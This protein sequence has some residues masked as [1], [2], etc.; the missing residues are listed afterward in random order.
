MKII[1]YFS[2][3][4]YVWGTQKNCLKE[5]SQLDGSFQHPKHISELIGEKVMT[6][7][8][9]KIFLTRPFQSMFKHV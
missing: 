5:L 4:T 8:S 3:K 7:S 2:T 1:F 9:S 6:I